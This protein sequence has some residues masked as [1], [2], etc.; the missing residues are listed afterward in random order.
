[1][2]DIKPVTYLLTFVIIL[3]TF[4]IKTQVTTTFS[5]PTT[6]RI[7]VIDPGHG[8]WDPGKTAGGT[9][10][11]E[12]NLKIAFKL[13]RLIEESGGKAIL[14]RGDNYALGSTKS[15]D[16]RERMEIARKHNAD[17][18]V[19]VHLNS[20]PQSKYFGAQ[21]FYY[22]S[23]K[24]G[25]ILAEAIQE[26][27]IKI[28]D[29]GNKRQAATSDNYYVLKNTY[30]PAVIV[31]CGFMSNPEEYKLLLDDGYQEKIAWAIYLGINKYFETME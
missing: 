3:T 12:I 23:S 14:T 11:S 17:I 20:F 6:S 22:S 5:L 31:E 24:N 9:K 1:M 16:M 15:S 30:M 18:F 29:R 4:Y 27:L 28:L 7:I 2:S 25:K 8:G 19:S 26:Q 10:E 13:K 21:T